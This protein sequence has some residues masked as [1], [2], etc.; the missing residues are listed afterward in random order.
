MAQ[1]S[2]LSDDTYLAIL[3]RVSN[4]ELVTDICRELAITRADVW[5]KSEEEITEG[6]GHTSLVS[7]STYMRA[8]ISQAHSMAEDTV[9]I[10][11]GRDSDGARRLSAMVQSLE[12]VDDDDKQR[13]LD[14][15]ASAA[16]QRDKL[17]VDTRKFLLAK[18]APRIYGD[19]T[20]HVELTGKDGGSIQVEDVTQLRDT[21]TARLAGIASRRKLLTATATIVDAEVVEPEPEPDI[22]T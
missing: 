22:V 5:R 1:R 18:I 3:D 21:L 13:L 8:R 4:G 9:L 6:N 12:G 17:R 7:L 16:V 15:L 19:T 20:R 10:A 14:S 11:D 2:N